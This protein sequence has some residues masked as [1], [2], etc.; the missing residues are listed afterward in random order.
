M[1]DDLLP[2]SALQHF[3][4]CPRQFAL[5]HIER[6]WMD[7]AATMQGSVLHHR[8]HEEGIVN[9]PGT[10]VVTAMPLRSD[11]VGLIGEA[12]RVELTR[13][14]SGLTVRPVEFKRGRPKRHRAD[15]VQLCAQAICLE[16]ML[17]CSITSGFL[18]YG[19]P[20]RRTDVLFDDALRSLTS[21]TA[22]AARA[23][24]DSGRTPSAE[25]SARKCSRCSL[26]EACQPRALTNK[27]AVSA[28]IQRELGEPCADS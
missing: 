18:F 5:I 10:R 23:L 14:G 1:D 2:I 17:G 15:E 9:R 7:D 28:W 8:V 20:R 16:E 25:Y 22:T 11:A 13:S 6:I 21:T 26:L 24:R 19:E 12:D 4:Y 27:R 3:V